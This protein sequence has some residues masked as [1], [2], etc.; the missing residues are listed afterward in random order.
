VFLDVPGCAQRC[1]GGCPES[2]KPATVLRKVVKVATRE[3]C[4]SK[5]LKVVKVRNTSDVIKVLTTRR[6]TVT[7]D[8]TSA[9]I[10]SNCWETPRPC[11]LM[12]QNRQECYRMCRTVRKVAE[13]QIVITPTVRYE[14]A[15][16]SA[17]R[18]CS[19][20]W[21][22]VWP[23]QQDGRQVYPG[24][25]DDPGSYA[26]WWS[27]LG[28]GV[29]PCPALLLSSL[30]CRTEVSAPLDAA[31]LTRRW[32]VCSSWCHSSNPQ[33]G[34]LL[35]VMPLLTRRRG[36]CSSLCRSSTHP[37]GV[38]SSSCFPPNLP[39]RCLLLVMP[40]F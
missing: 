17:V 23:W 4:F 18:R 2:E 9:R 8:D 5:L 25:Q 34:C 32:G 24:R 26:R 38:C 13:R 33:E 39:R 12:L 6:I 15:P 16:L 7:D 10:L 11:A 28:S 19:G 36:V 35:L 31:P 22:A 14:T 27:L 29:V 40:P 20:C 30:W 37:G 3:L 1:S 21:S